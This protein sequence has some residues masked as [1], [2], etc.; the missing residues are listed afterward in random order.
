MGKKKKTV[1]VTGLSISDIMNMDIDSF[2]KLNEKDLRAYTSRL[3]SASNKRIRALNKKGI[4]SPAVRS[5]GTRT[6]FSVKLPKGTDKTQRVNKLRQ[7]FSKARKFLSMQTSTIRG[8]KAHH[9]KVIETIESGLGRKLTGE[10]IS[11]AFSILHKAQELG[12]IDSK[13]GSKGSLQ[14]REIVFDILQDN[15]EISEND[16]L[17]KINERYDEWYQDYDDE[18]DE[19][20]IENG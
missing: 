9:K 4:D 6:G 2:N 8:A 17:D 14:A 1:D 11:Q 18:T 13:R 20:E 16:F 19:T 12:I 5:L 3:V 7:E 15:P 10:N